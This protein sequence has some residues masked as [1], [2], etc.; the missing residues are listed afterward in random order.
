[1][2]RLLLALILLYLVLRAVSRL[3]RGILAGLNGPQQINQPPAMPLV[4]DPVCGTFVVPANAPSFGTGSQMR[5]F[6]SEN[7]RRIYQAK[8]AR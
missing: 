5:F 7:C 3:G 2:L 4:R 1:M 8:S 6:C